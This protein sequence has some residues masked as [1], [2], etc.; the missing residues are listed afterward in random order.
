MVSAML[1]KKVGMTQIFDSDGNRVGVTVIEAGPCLVT[2]I[3]TPETDGY[4]AVQIGFGHKDPKRLRK[5]A[6]G[7]LKRLGE[8]GVRWLSEIRDPGE[9]VPEPGSEIRVADVFAEG[10]KIKVT[11]ITKGRG[12]AGVMKRHGFHG[13]PGGHG[14][15]VHRK[16]QSSGATDPARTFKGTKKPGHMGAARVTQRGLRVVSVDAERNLLLVSGA[17]PG[18]NKGLVLVT[19]D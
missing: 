8:R 15:M 4:L 10:D 14:S 1:G 16:P 6:A 17:V 11:G 12:F 3:K 9:E 2:Q 18:A 5:P 7:H 13:G 19:K